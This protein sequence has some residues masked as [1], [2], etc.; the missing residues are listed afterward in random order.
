MRSPLLKAPV[1]SVLRTMSLVTLLPRTRGSTRRDSMRLKNLSFRSEGD[2]AFVTR[3]QASSPAAKHW[4]QYLERATSPE[5]RG[6]VSLF[7]G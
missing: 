6:S 1:I 3:G 5:V 7:G 2:E 4:S